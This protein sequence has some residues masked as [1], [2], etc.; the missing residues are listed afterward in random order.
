MCSSKKI[1]DNVD[2]IE[3]RLVIP[4]FEKLNIK[5]GFVGI[6]KEPPTAFRPKQVHSTK[7]IEITSQSTKKFVNEK[8]KAD[9]IFTNDRN[10]PIAVVTADC[11]PVLFADKSKKIVM[12]VH[13]G[14]RGLAAGILKNAVK[15]C[16][17]S[18]A[19]LG[20]ILVG[21]GPAI[22]KEVY[23]VG[24]DVVG[25]INS[26]ELGLTDEQLEICIEKGRKDHF[27][28]DLQAV[29]IFTIFNC[30]I[31]TQNIGVIKSCTYKERNLW[32]SY[33]RDGDACGRNWSWIVL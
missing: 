14:W 6:D 22:S 27:Q 9:G 25:A 23:E 21:I 31:E 16:Q 8:L 24:H 26:K 33:R 29:S 19:G 12:A 20:E 18:G 3:N 7:I 2:W 15:I 17:E 4:H 13:A 5:H 1:F 30:G 32:A 11:V 10:V 28:L